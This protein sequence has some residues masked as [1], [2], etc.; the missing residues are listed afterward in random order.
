MLQ[1]RFFREWQDKQALLLGAQAAQAAQLAAQTNRTQQAT[2]NLFNTAGN[3][4]ALKNTKP[5]KE[6]DYWS[7]VEAFFKPK[8]EQWGTDLKS[9]G[10]AKFVTLDS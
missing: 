7:L 9:A 4:T 6:E 5:P 2:P 1:R 10:W 3:G 8:L